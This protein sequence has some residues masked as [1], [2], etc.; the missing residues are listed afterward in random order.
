MLAYDQDFLDDIFQ[1]F[2]SHSS[3]RCLWFLTT[4]AFKVP[5]VYIVPFFGLV[6]AISF[7]VDGAPTAYSSMTGNLK[8]IRPLT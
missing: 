7:G 6:V 4:V 5:N 2:F 3:V 8:K 1:R